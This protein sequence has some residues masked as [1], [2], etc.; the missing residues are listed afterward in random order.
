MTGRQKIKTALCIA[1]VAPVAA[2]IVILMAI[3]DLGEWIN[4]ALDEPVG[5]L[6]D[7]ANDDP[8]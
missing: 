7:W 1:L 2:V 6:F 8:A 4:M 3:G 5:R